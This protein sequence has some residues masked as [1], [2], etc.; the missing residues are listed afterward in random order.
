M[1]T[2][3][4]LF[5]NKHPKLNIG[6]YVIIKVSEDRNHWMSS[7]K[8]DFFES[9]IGIVDRLKQE[10]FGVEF[11]EKFDGDNYFFFDYDEIDFNSK[12]KT[13]AEAYLASK[14]YNL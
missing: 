8:I 5:E 2:N 13:D 14:K 9:N 11:E 4:K 7:D 3:F 6:D 1:I 12:N 10:Y